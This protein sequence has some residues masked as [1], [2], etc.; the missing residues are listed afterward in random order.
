MCRANSSRGCSCVCV[1]RACTRYTHADV[2]TYAH[3]YN[4][5][6]SRTYARIARACMSF[7][8]GQ[9]DRTRR[10]RSLVGGSRW[11]L[12]VRARYIDSRRMSESNGETEREREKER[13]RG[14]S[15]LVLPAFTRG[16]YGVRVFATRS[17]TQD[18]I[19][20]FSSRR[21]R[22]L[23][24]PPF[25]FLSPCRPPLPHPPLSVRRLSPRDAS[26]RRGSACEARF[27]K[28]RSNTRGNRLLIREIVFLLSPRS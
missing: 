14:S 24:A 28:R 8:E 21:R 7:R 22:R 13:E 11:K 10:R 4:F 12:I 26:S 19:D 15:V 1:S 9:E 16:L 27:V 3:T 25:S 2:R 20:R 17:T 23:V 18:A 5:T 6:R